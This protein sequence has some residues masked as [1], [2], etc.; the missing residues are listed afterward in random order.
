M[1]IHSL[2]FLLI[3]S[4]SSYSSEQFKVGQTYTLN[5]FPN[6]NSIYISVQGKDNHP[7][8]DNY[9]IV[10]FHGLCKVSK[11]DRLA[12][13]KYYLPDALISE[14]A[15]IESISGEVIP[16]H[17]N[18]FLCDNDQAPKEQLKLMLEGVKTGLHQVQVSKIT[19][20][21]SEFGDSEF[22]KITYRNS[23]K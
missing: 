17:D 3:I 23:K 7:Y 1:K 15:L 18:L 21:L 4:F 5:S 8:L 9:Y 22:Y 12:A 11:F 19:N 6:N 16:S 13:I 20:K 14:K 2:L 10:R